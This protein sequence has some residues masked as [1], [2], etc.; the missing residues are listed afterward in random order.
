MGQCPCCED[1]LL[2]RIH[3]GELQWFCRSCWQEMPLVSLSCKFEIA[4]PA[5]SHPQPVSNTL[6][7][8]KHLVHRPSLARAN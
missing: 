8:A 2:R 5:P 4:P 6:V 3:N 1:Q 7:S